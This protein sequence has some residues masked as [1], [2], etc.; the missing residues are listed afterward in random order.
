MIKMDMLRYKSYLKENFFYK[1]IPEM[2][3]ELELSKT[4]MNRVCW[5]NGYGEWISKL[6]KNRTIN[7]VQFLEPNANCFYFLGFMTADGWIRKNHIGIRISVKGEQLLSDISRFLEYKGAISKIVG[8]NSNSYTV[9]DRIQMDFN[10][11]IIVEFLKS[12]G[13]LEKKTLKENV[14]NLPSEYFWDFFRGFMDGDGNIFQGR[15]EVYSG[16]PIIDYLETELN[17]RGIL[18]KR[19]K[20]VHPDIARLA[21]VSS[22]VRKNNVVELLYKDSGSLR[23]RRKEESLRRWLNEHESRSST[24]KKVVDKVTRYEKN[25]SKRRV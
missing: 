5:A 13:M 2:A 8:E 17:K 15:I 22:E 21:I 18:T 25:S 4:T 12:H 1:S 20:R 16:G 11:R 3:E 7:E 10:S 14:V 9:C 24:N 23:L 6:N 19:Y